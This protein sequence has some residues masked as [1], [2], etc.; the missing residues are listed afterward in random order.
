MD[1]RTDAFLSLFHSRINYTDM[2]LAIL[3]IKHF[4]AISQK[5]K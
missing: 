5:C 4:Q 2:K 1:F 3:L